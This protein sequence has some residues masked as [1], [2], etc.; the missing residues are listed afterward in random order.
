[1]A[2]QEHSLQF[3]RNIQKRFPFINDP[4]NYSYGDNYVVARYCNFKKTPKGINGE[5][6]HGNI[7]PERNFHPELVIGSD[8]LSKFR[9][10]KKYYVARQDQVDYLLKEG[11]KNVIAI[12]LP[13]VYVEKPKETRIKNS[14][15]LM[16]SHSLSG[17]DYK[18]AEVKFIDSIKHLF[19]TFDLVVCCIH[20]NDFDKNL[21]IDSM[22]KEGIDT[23]IGADDNDANTYPRLASLFS[24]FEYLITDDFGSHIA[25]A[26]YFGCKISI[27]ENQHIDFEIQNFN[28]NKLLIEAPFYKNNPEL[29]EDFVRK[30]KK[31]NLYKKYYPFFYLPIRNSIEQMDWASFQLGVENIKTPK[32]LRTIFGWDNP[33]VHWVRSNVSFLKH[34]III[35]PIKKVRNKIGRCT[36]KFILRKELGIF[37]HLTLDER[38]LLYKISN[39]LPNNAVCVEI[40][41][42]LGASSSIIAGRLK[43]G[44]KLYCIDTWGNHAMVYN[45][46]D[47]HDEALVEKW[48]LPEF[49]KNTIN[50][51]SKIIELQGW[52]YDM[53][54]VLKKIENQIDFLFIDGDH[55]YEGVKQDWDLYSKLLLPGS[56]VAFHDTGW[57][58]GVIRVVTDEVNNN[59]NLIHKL[60]NLQV[61]KIK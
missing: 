37:S 32:K 19:P 48:T 9:K 26:S 35:K 59:A 4:Y 50:F 28:W 25:Y 16:P 55:N 39:N 12:G 44:A 33:L 60:P 46:D 18:V 34:N 43:K 14:L 49:R 23:L 10:E 22:K 6:Q 31:E 8:G 54:N 36:L 5:W 41:S 13:I 51:K 61:F 17:I 7:I 56:I 47:I 30:F 24:Q 38:M 57:A 42:Y 21:W 40:G 45:E 27:I 15:L 2:I 52:S 1:M 58:E 29:I 53:I 20:K 3:V 11:F